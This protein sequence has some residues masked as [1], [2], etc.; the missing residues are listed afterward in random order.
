MSD[1]QTIQKIILNMY[2]S[3]SSSDEA[4]YKALVHP[5]VRTVNIGNSG[6]VHVFALR[7]DHR[8]HDQRSE[9]RR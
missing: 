2:Q 8:I 7:A 6:E 9:E 5:Q 3:L 4:A 1:D